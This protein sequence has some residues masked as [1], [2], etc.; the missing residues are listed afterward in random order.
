MT[1]LAALAAVA[2]GAILLDVLIRR[3][4]AGAVVVVA[5]AV[6]DAL[7]PEPL[8]VALGPISVFASDIAAALLATATAARLLRAGRL[9]AVQ[10]ILVGLAA[11]ALLS[12]ARGAQAFGPEP[13]LNEFRR[14]LAVLA[15][16]LYFSTLERSRNWYDRLAVVWLGG[17]ALL[18]ALALVRWAALS[19][20]VS[21]GV[22]GDGSVRVLPAP[23]AL[24]I[25][26]GFFVVLP[27]WR[28]HPSPLLR[29]AA[30]ALLAVV[31]LLQHRTV[32]VVLAAGIAVLAVRGGGVD[33][34]LVALVGSGLVLGAVLGLVLLDGSDLR[35]GEQLSGSAT[36][37]DTFAWRYEGWAELL[38]R[39]DEAGGWSALL[40]GLPFGSGWTRWVNGGYVE[41]SP[42]NFYLEAYLRVGVVGL[43][44]LLLA[45]ALVVRARLSQPDHGGL[46]N[47]EVLLVLVAS[48]AVYWITYAPDLTQSLVLGL[49]VASAGPATRAAR[50]PRPLAVGARA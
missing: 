28:R 19:V 33:R 6:V 44:L 32:W 49:A 20:G 35:L 34:Q 23:E 11:V 36:N 26:Q 8:Q 38:E 17:I 50:R 22:F 1:A 30:P 10:W 29:H 41:V 7:L 42:H 3:T 47:G 2:A 16:T 31:V 45:G 40:V 4:V 25:A 24:V 15:G 9:G 37:T 21:G 13:A 14:W 43:V 46:F 5:V 39:A 27:W 18:V 48:Q 12:V